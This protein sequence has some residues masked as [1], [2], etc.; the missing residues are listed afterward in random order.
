MSELQHQFPVLLRVELLG[1]GQNIA[2][3]IAPHV[4]DSVR[5][6][7]TRIELAAKS[8]L[9]K[10]IRS[11]SLGITAGFSSAEAAVLGAREMHR[12]CA[13]IRQTTEPK[14]GVQ[15]GIHSDTTASS[16]ALVESAAT[17]LASLLGEGGIVISRAIL[18]SLKPDLRQT[19]YPLVHSSAWIPAHAIRWQENE[20]P[21]PSR[22]QMPSEE[23]VE[24]PM[25]I[26]VLRMG[27]R[28]FAFGDEKPVITLG[29]DPGSDIVIDDPK[30]SRAHLRIINQRDRCVVVDQSTNGTYITPTEGS[31]MMVKHEMAG[32]RGTGWISLGQPFDRN[33][34]YVI[35]FQVCGSAP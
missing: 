20:A 15:I 27:Q 19:A 16:L 8:Y 22:Y 13:A 10:I 31:A 6:H 35:E 3:D 29:R 4:D 7:I 33:N 25:P 21:S 17:K 9:G 28:K 11:T 30:A 34:R 12:R 23:V 24:S 1:P 26:I 5:R 2:V 32:L 18:E 14:L